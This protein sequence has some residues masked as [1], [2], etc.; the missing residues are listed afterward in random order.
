MKKFLHVSLLGAVLV[1]PFAAQAEDAYV[2]LAAG[3][4]SYKV[5]EFGTFKQNGYLLG[6]GV[7][8]D[9]TWDVEVGYADLGKSTKKIGNLSESVDVN[10]FYAAGI[11]KYPVSDAFNLF[12]KLGIGYLRAEAELKGL[13]GAST[14][15]LKDSTTKV[16]YGVGA[17]YNFTKEIA[18]VIDYTAYTSNIK[19]LSAGVR[20]GF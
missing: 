9:K 18:G 6:L 5:D 10:V 2:K 8:L 14:P 19:Y 13:G 1:T 17:S 3:Q 4:S 11:G 7:A 20:Y 12:G 16:L 15:P